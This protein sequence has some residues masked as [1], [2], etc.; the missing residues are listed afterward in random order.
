MEVMKK[1]FPL[2]DDT[3]TILCWL[4]VKVL[5]PDDSLKFSCSNF[6]HPEVHNLH[7]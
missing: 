4:V 6:G 7:I 1:V 5:L 2:K 3:N